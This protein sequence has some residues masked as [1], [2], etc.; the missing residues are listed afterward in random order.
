MRYADGTQAISGESGQFHKAA[1]QP[2]AK[3]KRSIPPPFSIRFSEEER[4]R[5]D[6]AAGTLSLAAYMRLKL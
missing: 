2:T 4:A 3:K 1:I 5:L 6:R